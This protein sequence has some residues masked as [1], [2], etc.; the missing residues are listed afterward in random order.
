M[1]MNADEKTSWYWR[2]SAVIHTLSDR[3]LGA[4]QA[5]AGEMSRK[6]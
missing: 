3:L 1:L 2:L 5:A 4:R 6:F